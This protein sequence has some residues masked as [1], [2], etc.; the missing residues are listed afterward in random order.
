MVEL[1]HLW[2][3]EAYTY[4]LLSEAVVTGHYTRDQ[5][6]RALATAN[7][8]PEGLR[9]AFLPL[10][11]GEHA[12]FA[13]IATFAQLPP[14]EF[15]WSCLDAIMTNSDDQDLLAG[16]QEAAQR[17]FALNQLPDWAR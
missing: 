11:Q 13:A 6:K 14:H 3:N 1:L 10:T 2:R 7:F 8:G 5:A 17:R 16:A 9:L 4:R 12:A 15:L